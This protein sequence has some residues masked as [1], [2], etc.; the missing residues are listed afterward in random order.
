M[1]GGWLLVLASSAVHLVES[2]RAEPSADDRKHYVGRSSEACEVID[3]AC[4]NGWSGFQDEKGCGCLAPPTLARTKARSKKP[5][6]RRL[7]GAGHRRR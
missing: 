2:P 6:G 5:C 1:T 7:V 3:Y 4:P